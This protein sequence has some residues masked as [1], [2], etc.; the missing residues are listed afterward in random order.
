MY[1]F[2]DPT[3]VGNTYW[4]GAAVE[5][6]TTKIWAGQLSVKA[7]AKSSNETMVRKMPQSD[8]FESLKIYLYFCPPD[9]FEFRG[10]SA[11]WLDV[12]EFSIE[13]LRSLES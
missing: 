10:E 1:M 7:I 6:G 13:R 12:I 8:Y 3:F 2:D 4:V 11:L 5:I 9:V